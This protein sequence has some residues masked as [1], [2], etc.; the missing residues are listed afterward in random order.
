MMKPAPPEYLKTKGNRRRV[1]GIDRTFIE[2]IFRDTSNPILTSLLCKTTSHLFEDPSFALFVSLGE[3]A[4]CHSL[5]KSKPVKLG[6][7]RI[8]C[9]NEVS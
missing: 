7:M 5:A 3:I 8:E 1:K 4:S 9:R 6:L 2:G